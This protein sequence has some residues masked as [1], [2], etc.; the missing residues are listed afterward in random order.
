MTVFDYKPSKK[1]T[2]ILLS[3]KSG[4]GKDFV[5]N[6]MKDIL[7]E[8]G[9]KVLIT[10]YADLLKYI[11]KT[12][13]NWDGK[14][15]ENGRQLLQTVGTAKIRNID[16]DFW[17]DFIRFILS[18]FYK[19]W[20]YVLIPDARFE[21]EIGKI[22]NNLCASYN[23]ITVRV[24]R[25]NAEPKLTLEQQQHES[26]TALDDYVFDYYYENKYDE[27]LSRTKIRDF[28]CFIIGETRRKLFIDLDMTVFNTVQAITRMYNEDF[29]YYPDFEQVIWTD[30]KSWGFNE[31]SLATPEYIANCFN[32]SRFFD[33]VKMFVDAEKVIYKL[34]HKYNIV[35]VSH[36][37]APNLRLKKRY[38]ENYFPYAEFIGVDIDEYEDKS[39]VDMSG[40]G[41]IFIDD[42]PK[43][44]N[45][46][47]AE[48]KICYGDYE[49][50]KGNEFNLLEENHY[51]VSDW[52]QIEDLLL[53]FNNS[54]NYCHYIRR[55]TWFEDFETE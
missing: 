18:A 24:E 33:K 46:S 39:C 30:V 5:A 19:V 14:K 51:K 55:P 22:K 44:L 54:F 4:S 28:L 9:N 52:G 3:G 16:P 48:I 36:G 53:Y 6:T 27:A 17:V 29:W 23:V 49:W 13:F 42:I 43:N 45:N 41:N 11:L 31:L 38:I 37:N 50:N 1:P 21:N 7:E 20:D 2:I 12:F 26:E 15:D 35:F 40:R 10:H 47:N 25:N 34:R 32:Q 8:D